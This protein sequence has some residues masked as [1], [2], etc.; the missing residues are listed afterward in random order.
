MC[1][2]EF[3]N[4]LFFKYVRRCITGHETRENGN[5]C[6]ADGFKPAAS[7]DNGFSRVSERGSAR[8]NETRA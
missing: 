6:A 5:D 4:R 8:T 2:L 3:I 1:F 7:A